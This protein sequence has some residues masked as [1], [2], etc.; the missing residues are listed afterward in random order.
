L[1]DVSSFHT[2]PVPPNWDVKE[3]W[4]YLEEGGNFEDY[5]EEDLNW[6]VVEVEAEQKFVRVVPIDEKDN[7][8]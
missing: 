8:D 1:P 3:A 2:I 4:N 5:R 7:D 6:A